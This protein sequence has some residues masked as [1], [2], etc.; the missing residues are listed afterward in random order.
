VTPTL[1]GRLEDI[2]VRLS[3]VMVGELVPSPVDPVTAVRTSGGA[4]TSFAGFGRRK[5]AQT[6][7]CGMT[8]MKR[9]TWKRISPFQAE[10][11]FE[12]SR[13]REMLGLLADV[14]VGTGSARVRIQQHLCEADVFVRGADRRG[15]VAS[16]FLPAIVD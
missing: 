14:V 1:N 5:H 12:V 9:R 8:P 7:P 13:G 2:A 10:K 16:S 15:G 11:Y 3:T 4:I 6:S